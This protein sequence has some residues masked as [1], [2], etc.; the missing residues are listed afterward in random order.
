MENNKAEAIDHKYNL[1]V[2]I[3]FLKKYKLLFFGILGVIFVIELARVVTRYFFKIAI[4]SGT[5]F[6]AGVLNR[7]QII[8]ILLAVLLGYLLT[9]GINSLFKWLRI[10]FINILDSKLIKDVKTDFFNHILGLSHKFHVTHKTGSLISKVIRGGHAIERMTDTIFFRFCPLLFQVIVAMASFIYFDYWSAITVGVTMIA[11]ITYSY[12][13]QMKQKRAY[14]NYNDQEDFEKANVSDFLTNIDSIR[15]FAKER[16]IKSK[17]RSLTEKT[18][19]KSLILWDYFKWMD[20]G[21][22]AI[23]SIGTAFLIGLPFVKFVNG[24]MELGTIA[25]IY[26]VYMNIA[27]HLYGFVSGIR[28]Y[29]RAMADF[30][31]MFR[32]YKVSNEVK[33]KKDAKTLRVRKG[34]IE[35]KNM[36]FG[37]GRKKLFRNFNLKIP[38]NTKVAL[39]GHSGCGKSSL[40]KLL[41]RLYD[42]DKGRI[43]IDGKDIR[44]LKKKSLRSE[45]SIVTQECVL[46]DD[47]VY[48]NIAFSN[49][50]AS[51]KDVFKAMKFAQLDKI[52]KEFPNKEKTIV[53]ERGVRLSGGEKQRVSIARAILANKKILILDEATSSLDSQTEHEIQKDLDDL[54]EGRTAII[55]A[56]RLSTIMK[57]DMIVVMDKGKIVQMGNHE[58]LVKK[59]G[60]Y[61][62]LWSLQKGGYIE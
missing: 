15:Y 59:G 37:Y 56:H 13:I 47:T 33:D 44:N 31:S 32:F 28:N 20:A 50:K 42:V 24:T 51:R 12:V 52:V 11:F 22:T 54:M 25:F 55:I 49:P 21:Q 62:K 39:V 36:S 17:Y 7:S 1:K 14:K 60:V 38:K 3:G 41:F 9:Q 23:L 8:S 4:D 34:I 46:F 5:D 40:I 29:Y 26:T 6:S 61:K 43:L 30:E 48:N 18:K 45:M 57:A 58:D 10:H 27:G 53:G 19:I 35:F 2:Y 16:K